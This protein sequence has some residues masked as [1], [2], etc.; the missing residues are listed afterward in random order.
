MRKQQDGDRGAGSPLSSFFL[1]R[2]GR[3]RG[4]REKP[5]KEVRKRGQIPLTC[6]KRREKGETLLDSH[7]MASTN[8]GVQQGRGVDQRREKGEMGNISVLWMKEGGARV[9]RTE[10]CERK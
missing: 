2:S 6:S 4:G 9:G 7:G 1:R 8:G 10:A 5:L 3:E